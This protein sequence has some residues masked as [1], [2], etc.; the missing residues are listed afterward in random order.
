ME[1]EDNVGVTKVTADEITLTKDADNI[2]RGVLRAKEGTNNVFI[3][4][5]DVKGNSATSK[6]ISYT[7]MKDVPPSYNDGN[8]NYDKD[9]NEI[10]SVTVTKNPESINYKKS[11]STNI[12]ENIKNKMN[13]IMKLF[14]F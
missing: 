3:V 12:I 2:W 14:K 11:E 13:Y 6:S 7:T 8:R 9:T 10:P 5:Q 1:A 4:A